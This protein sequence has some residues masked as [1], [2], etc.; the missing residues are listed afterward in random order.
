MR[1]P[2][3]ARSF[4]TT[5]ESSEGTL[6]FRRA[7]PDVVRMPA[8]SSWSFTANGMPWSGPRHAPVAASACARSASAS[9]LSLQTV[10]KARRRPSSRPMRSR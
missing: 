5:V 10:M 9:A 2:P 7:E 8:V 3:A 6:P 1:I 4:A